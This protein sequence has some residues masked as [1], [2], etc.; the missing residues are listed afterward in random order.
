[1]SSTNEMFPKRN[2]SAQA[3]RV[4]ASSSAQATGV[5]ASRKGKKEGKN[6][7]ISISRDKVP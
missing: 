1:M 7:Y 5:Q 6:I 3:I 2:M 4:Q